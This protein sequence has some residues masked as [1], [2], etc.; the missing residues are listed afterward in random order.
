MSNALRGRKLSPESIEKMRET[1]TGVPS[2]RKGIPR[3]NVTKQKIKDKR[4][5]QIITEE[6]KLKVSIALGQQV[7]SPTGDLYHSVREAS[8]Q[9]GIARHIIRYSIKTNSG[10]VLI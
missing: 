4:K 7:L 6:T 2:K 1:K 10:W 9:T 8:K 5:N 3:D